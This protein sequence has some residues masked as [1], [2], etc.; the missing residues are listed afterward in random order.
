VAEINKNDTRQGKDIKEGGITNTTTRRRARLFQAYVF[1]TVVGFIGLAFLANQIAY[2]PIDL[3]I[4]HTVQTFHPVWFIALM[5]LV[6]WPGY[7]PQTIFIVLLFVLV[8]Y[9]RGLRWTAITSCGGAIGESALNVAIKLLIHRP[10]P[11]ATLVYVMQV[12]NSYSFPSGHVMFYSVFF[13]FLIFIIYSRLKVSLFRN[14][15]LVF[16]GSLVGLVGVSRI[17]L[18][19]HW[20]SDVLGGYLLGS[21]CLLVIIRIY[22]WGASRDI[23]GRSANRLEK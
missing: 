9:L 7:L 12:L 10:R 17:Y 2:F 15:L 14:L 11:K 19:E 8:L 5:V 6:S 16:F 13:G 22:L 4:T 3:W 23:T 18:G 21:L 20:A 1:A